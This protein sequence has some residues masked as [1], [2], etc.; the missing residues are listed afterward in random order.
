M[1]FPLSYSIFKWPFIWML[2]FLRRSG[3]SDLPVAVCRDFFLINMTTVLQQQLHR[4]SAEIITTWMR[5]LSLL[6]KD[7][8][9][10]QQQRT[11]WTLKTWMC[12]ESVPGRE[13]YHNWKRTWKHWEHWGL[14]KKKKLQG[15]LMAQLRQLSQK[16]V[17]VSSPAAELRTRTALVWCPSPNNQGALFSHIDLAVVLLLGVKVPI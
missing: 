17:L 3:G 2:A 11:A 5:G 10:I 9:L 15:W 1:F 6:C 4:V 12:S 8:P 13:A 16:A 7:H 14:K